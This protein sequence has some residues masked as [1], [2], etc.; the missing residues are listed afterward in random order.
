M[1][2]HEQVETVFYVK[3]VREPQRSILRA[4]R[5]HCVGTRNYSTQGVKKD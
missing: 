2:V 4:D 3:H 5:K 1:K